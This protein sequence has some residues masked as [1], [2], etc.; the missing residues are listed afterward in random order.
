MS[1]K[2][3]ATIRSADDV[4]SLIE[5]SKSR[6]S[7]W[8]VAIALG[9]TF[10]DG[11]DFAA[12]GVGSSQIKE[13]FNPSPAL[14]GTTTAAIAIGALLGALVGGY[15]VDKIGRKR[16][17]GFDLLFF[18]AAAIGSALSPDT[19]WL[20]FFRLIMGIGVG[21]D[22]PVAL[23]FIAESRGHRKRASALTAWGVM[24]S[25]GTISTY[26]VAL[27]VHALG[28]GDHTWRIVLGVGA[29]PAIL[30]VVA[31]WIFIEESP[32]WLATSGDL[33]GAARVLKATYGIE[34]TV[35]DEAAQAERANTYSLRNYLEVLSPKYL[36]RTIVVSLISLTQ[37]MQFYAVSFY[38]P[39]IALQLF[40]KD[41]Y[42][43]TFGSML[44][45]VVMP[46]AT[47]IA[48][49]FVDKKGPRILVVIGYAGVLL[50]LLVIGITFDALPLAVATAAICLFQ[51]FH[52]LGPGTLGMTMSAMSY[53]TEIRGAGVGVGQAVLRVGSILGFYIFPLL[54][55]AVGLQHTLLVLALVPAVG[56]IGTL[57]IKWKAGQAENENTL[58]SAA[59]SR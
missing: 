44:L 30:V 9:C 59:A 3:A 5:N 11:Y 50:S 45:A 29:L 41:F 17:L 38:L 28:G 40:G 27:M 46:I 1:E 53:P 52:G 42:R 2:T 32:M 21:M 16:M 56:L 4:A 48:M 26:V 33:H 47:L 31:R 39:I 24:F 13:Q 43:A 54:L 10:L 34:A 6:R 49:R 55:A 14:F 15:F 22:F 36:M 57:A 25:V 35:D 12:L 37:S 18:V 58:S 23:S 19:Y 51:F 8:I 20:I 7:N